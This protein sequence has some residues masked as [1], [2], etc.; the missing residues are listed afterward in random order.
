MRSCCRCESWLCAKPLASRQLLPYLA[1]LQI[2]C[3]L[4]EG[5]K[6]CTFAEALRAHRF[7]YLTDGLWWLLTRYM[8]ILLPA[9]LKGAG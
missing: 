1:L 9:C 2:W 3:V 4:Y 7:V 6:R 8:M 5:S